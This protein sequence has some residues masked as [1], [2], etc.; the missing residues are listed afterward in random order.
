MNY[1]DT[2]LLEI[3]ARGVDKHS[4]NELDSDHDYR[5]IDNELPVCPICHNHPRAWLSEK[6]DVGI[7][8]CCNFGTVVLSSDV[9]EEP[10]NIFSLVRAWGCGISREM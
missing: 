2:G 4:D 5:R 3:W 8:R 7:L 9:K 6:K 10:V 1:I